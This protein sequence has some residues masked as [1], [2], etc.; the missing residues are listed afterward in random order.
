MSIRSTKIFLT[1]IVLVHFFGNLWHGD[2]HTTL[3]ISLPG[4]KTLLVLIVILVGPIVGAALSWT[5]YFLAGGWVVGV[6]MLGS[7][8]FSVYHH[9]VMV[10]NDNVHFL[11]PGSP[12][13]HEHFT[14]SAE[15]IALVALAGALFAFYS[16]GKQHTDRIGDT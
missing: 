7:V 16:V 14:S 15:L 3:E 4:Y 5:K 10:S 12:E 9:Y 2:A 8:L 11:P 1:A 13:A 6:C